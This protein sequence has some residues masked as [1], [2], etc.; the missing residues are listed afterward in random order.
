MTPINCRAV[1]SDVRLNVY[2][3]FL[4]KTIVT[5]FIF[6][7]NLE[8]DSWILA[9]GAVLNLLPGRVAYNVLNPAFKLQAKLL[10][11][12]SSRE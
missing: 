7:F 1:I 5:F 10:Q 9:S 8:A 2:K 6:G 11:H 4:L 3:P 12:N